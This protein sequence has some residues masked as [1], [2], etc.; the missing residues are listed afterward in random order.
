MLLHPLRMR[1]VLVL[2]ADALTTKQIH[3]RLPDVAQASLYRAIARLVD[4]GVIVVVERR[5]RGGALER[6]YRAAVN[7]EFATASATPAE[8]VAAANAL[9]RSLSLDATRHAA[10]DWSPGSA[11]L[12]HES[13]Q[14]APA[15]FELL[16]R[17]LIELLAALSLATPG[18]GSKGY[19]VTVAAIPHAAVPDEAV[20]AD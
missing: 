2:G 17:Q 13:I 6:V 19:S 1:V 15:Q 3:Q 7:A 14:L 16:R 11:G 12:V 5:R 10:A 18:D 4:A 20:S 9:A 8:F